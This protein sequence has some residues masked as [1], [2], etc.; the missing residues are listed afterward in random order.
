M[1]T[2]RRKVIFAN[3]LCGNMTSMQILGAKM[4]FY[5]RLIFGGFFEEHFQRHDRK[6]VGHHC[7]LVVGGKGYGQRSQKA[8]RAKIWVWCYGKGWTSE[9]IQPEKQDKRE[10]LGEKSQ[11]WYHEWV[12]VKCDQGPE[13]CF[14]NRWRKRYARDLPAGLEK[15]GLKNSARFNCSL[16]SWALK[17][18]YE[19]ASGAVAC[20]A[21]KASYC[22]LCFEKI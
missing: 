7:G 9:G 21:D 2:W 20:M 11:W 14:S 17:E 12:K 5:Q 16:N 8:L 3:V 10:R 18:R 6:E 4:D 15:L 22:P 19:V 13:K 1:G